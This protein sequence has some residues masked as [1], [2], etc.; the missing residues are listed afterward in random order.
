MIKC[1]ICD[2]EI[3]FWNKPGF[4]AGKT[5]NGDTICSNCYL[6]LR[7][8]RKSGIIATEDIETARKA[9]IDSDYKLS[10][11]KQ[12]ISS[13]VKIENL[14][15]VMGKSTISKLSEFIDND[16]NICAILIGVFNGNVLVT[17]TDKRLIFV[18]KI[19][20]KGVT[21]E[22]FLWDN[23]VSVDCNL[24][25]LRADVKILFQGRSFGVTQV[26][27]SQAK[28]FC[29]EVKLI[30]SQKKIIVLTPIGTPN[31]IRGSVNIADE[32]T[33]LAKLK[34]QGFLTQE[35]FDNQ[36]KKLLNS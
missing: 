24:G 28:S 9:I 14:N 22:E 19:I 20:M 25:I 12:M 11:F 29:T 15:I 32:L 36:K 34:E 33:K 7:D 13:F 30:Q 4:G 10:R 35:E 27:N 26:V 23:L 3:T 21:T 31:L 8:E 6:K 2:N 1:P 5:L 16:E 17:A 18:T